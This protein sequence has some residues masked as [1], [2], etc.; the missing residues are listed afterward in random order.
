MDLSIIYQGAP[1]GSATMESDGIY[2][3][4]VCRMMQSSNEPIRLYGIHSWQSEYLGIPD[5]EGRLAARIAKKHLPDGAETILASKLPNGSWKPW[6]GE[7]DGVKVENALLQRDNG[8][9]LALE[10]D[11]A[12]R[13]PEWIEFMEKVQVSDSERLL[14][15]LDENGNLPEIEKKL[16]GTNNETMDRDAPAF[17]LH[18][19]ASSGNDDNRIGGN[20]G[21]EQGWEADSADF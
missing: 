2:W 4:I 5:A 11:E 3:K 10:S 20:N 9:L 6:A 7:V 1:V 17:E 12:V 16:G 13:F 18:P 21:T 8:I 14:L 15:R 19:D